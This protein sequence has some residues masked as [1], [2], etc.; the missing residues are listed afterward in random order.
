MGDRAARYGNPDGKPERQRTDIG[1]RSHA[2]LAGG[3][4]AGRF[5]RR[6]RDFAGPSALLT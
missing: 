3:L 6:G 4:R 2:A 5:P 1:F